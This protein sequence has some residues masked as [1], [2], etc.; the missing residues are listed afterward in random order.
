MAA[1]VNAEN[2]FLKRQQI[3]L[4]KF[5]HIRHADL[6]ALLVFLA[7]EIKQTHLAFHA[8]LLLFVLLVQ[9][10]RRDEQL[11]SAVA[12]QCVKRSRLD[13]VFQGPLVDLL[14]AEPPHKIL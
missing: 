14:V 6:E 10:I 11:L 8:G 1:D 9:N 12:G 2:F 5:F 4:G 13:K 7:G 3:L